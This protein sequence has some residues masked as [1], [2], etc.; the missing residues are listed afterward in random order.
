MNSGGEY[1]VFDASRVYLISESKLTR[2]AATA[3]NLDRIEGKRSLYCVHASKHAYPIE[4]HD[5]DNVVVAYNMIP[6]AFITENM[7]TGKQTGKKNR[8]IGRVYAFR[9]L[10]YSHARDMRKLSHLD[11]EDDKQAI[12]DKTK[13]F[14]DQFAEN[15]VNIDVKVDF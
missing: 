3:L 11:E 2:K 7:K 14:F 1:E 15:T 5:G 9:R 8:N 6:W 10:F 12:I 13:L 4:L